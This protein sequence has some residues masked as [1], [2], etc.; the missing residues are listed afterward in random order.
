MNFNEESGDKNESNINNG[1]DDG[2]I[3]DLLLFERRLFPVLF[4]NSYTLFFNELRVSN[5]QQYY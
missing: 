1:A 5:D 4:V 3:G 2:I